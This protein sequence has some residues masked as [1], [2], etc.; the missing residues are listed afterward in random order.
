MEKYEKLYNKLVFPTKD[1]LEDAITEAKKVIKVQNWILYG[2]DALNLLLKSHKNMSLYGEDHRA[3]IDCYVPNIEDVKKV[4]N[5]IFEHEKYK[6][7]RQVQAI[8]ENTYK[9]NVDMDRSALID[10]TVINDKLFYKIPYEVIGGIRVTSASYLIIDLLVSILVTKN[11]FRFTKSMHRIELILNQLLIKERT[12]K[13]L[14]K[15]KARRSNDK[16][17]IRHR[18][19]DTKRKDYLISKTYLDSHFSKLIMHREVESN[20]IKTIYKKSGSKFKYY[21]LII[22]FEFIT[23]SSL[24]IDLFFYQILMLN[25][26]LQSKKMNI[27]Y[28]MVSSK[29]NVECWKVLRNGEKK[30]GQTNFETEYKMQI[31]FFDNKSD[32]ILPSYILSR[33]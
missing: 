31:N 5:A 25:E 21:H 26:T 16:Y 19:F 22:D 17:L 11:L 1:H 7:V 33:N 15:W 14:K 32:K 8:H 6:L 24:L 29:Y 13:K 9:I 27:L 18:I 20:Y 2:G 4:S 28:N 10:C 30:I 23:A 12:K 3:D